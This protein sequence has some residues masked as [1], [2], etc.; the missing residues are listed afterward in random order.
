MDREQSINRLY[1]DESLTDNLA[2]DEAEELLSWAESHLASLGTDKDAERLLD[3]IRLV[4]RY[5]K[6][7]EPFEGL[8]VALRAN[9]LRSE[10]DDLSIERNAIDPDIANTY[11]EEEKESGGEGEGGRG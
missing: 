4:N 5:V 2:D 10:T 8:F 7:G 1:N 9:A 11:P 3:S 6:E